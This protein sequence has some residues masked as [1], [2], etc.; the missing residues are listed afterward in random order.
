ML[1]LSTPVRGTDGSVVTEIPVP[2]GTNIYVSIL[3]S[4]RNGE[5]WGPDALEWKPERWLS[6]LPPPLLEA[7]IPGI[8]SHL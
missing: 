7:K 4:N 2:A 3:N 6:P 8:Y 1:P 5:L